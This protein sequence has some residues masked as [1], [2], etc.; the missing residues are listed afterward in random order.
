[1]IP[2]NEPIIWDEND[3]AAFF[4]ACDEL[5]KAIE[6]AGATPL[7]IVNILGFYFEQK[8]SGEIASPDL[9]NRMAAT[10]ERWRSKAQTMKENA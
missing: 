1:L 7:E 3:K 6:E 4:T 5:D 8:R 9:I 10:A 2:E